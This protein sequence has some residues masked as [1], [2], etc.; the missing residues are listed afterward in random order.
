MS[1]I[2]VT[3]VILGLAVIAFMSNRVP[4][5]IVALGVALSL[6]AT[7]ILT[8]NQALAGFG[9]PTVIFIAT[10]FVVS[11]ALDSTG[12]TAWA[13]QQVIGRGGTQR[14]QL[15]VM[16]CALVAVLTALISVNGAV[17]AL[18]PVVV[19]VAIRVG[20]APSKMLMPLAF[21][22]HAGSMLALTGTP[23]NIIVSEAAQEAGARSFGFFEFAL[24][25]LPLVLG[26]IGFI[27]AFGDRLLPSRAPSVLPQDVSDYARLLREQYDLP[28][29]TELVGARQ[30]SSEVIVAPRS[31]LIGLH[32]F[33]GMT[34]PSGDLVVLGLQRG[35]VPVL[36]PE[37]RLRAG[38]TLLL[39][40]TWEHLEQHTAGPAV[41]VVDDPA[42]LRRSVPLGTGAKRAVAVLAA[43]VVLLATGVVPPA[44]AGLLAAGAIILG[45][46]LTPTQAYRSI[47]WTTV[48]LVAGMIP[49]STAFISTGTADLIAG[50]LLR[51]LGDASPYFALLAICTLAMILGQL[52]SNTATVL[53]MAP[54]AT[55]LATDMG[56]SV[57]P[58]LMALTVAGAASFLTPVATAAN[59]MVMEPGGYRFTDYW[60]L[61]LPLLVL[62]LAV[63]VLWVP[64]IWRF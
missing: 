34:T 3:L 40:G 13:G 47:S 5:G 64:L 1:P 31:E 14:T 18:I 62:F 53:I 10:L 22:A 45:R 37:V 2:I 48:V 46:V 56:V 50:G 39:R 43:M 11:E 4:M 44:V 42:D 36:G 28:A 58:F 26:T 29:G 27:V 24:V 52:I 38:D 8:L 59:T 15:L 55:A 33:P 21:S 16:I 57:L 7:G 63:A 60:K 19:V 54:I 61:G 23:V 9:D 30:G 49:L 20:L 41:V 32:L 35:G 12:V 25:G 17:A 51:L 6:W